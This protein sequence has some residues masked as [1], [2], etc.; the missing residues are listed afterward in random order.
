MTGTQTVAG[1]CHCG[2]VRYEAEADLGQ[3][4]QCNCSHC[5]KKGFILAFTPAANFRLLSGEEQLT[6][7]RFH[8]HRIAH[9]FCSR[10]G[11]QAF[12]FGSGPDGAP[13]AALNLRC[14]DGLDLAA[15]EPQPFDGKSL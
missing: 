1:G 10:C 8:R 14:V 5:A 9:R 2:A 11:V 4:M 3:T 7:Y 15:L 13:M 12:A 6:E